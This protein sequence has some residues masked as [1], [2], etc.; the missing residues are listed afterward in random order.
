[1]AILN[2][3]LGVGS[4]SEC[5]TND[6]INKAFPEWESQSIFNKVGINSRFIC[7]KDEDSLTLALDA[8]QD[9]KNKYT[10][11]DFDFLIY[12]SNSS[13]NQAPGDG[14][15]FLKELG[16]KGNIGCID[17]NLGCSGFTY[18]LGLA[19]SLIDSGNCSKV[20]I[21]TTDAYSKF[22]SADDKSNMTLFGDG[23]TSSIVSKFPLN[24]KGWLLNN[25]KFGSFADACLD[26][27]IVNDKTR[28]NKKLIMDGK[29]IF[30]FSAN[31]V[32]KFISGQNVDFSEFTAIFHQANTFM[33][34]Y[35][36]RKLKISD[37]NFII[38][39]SE[40]GNTVSASIPYVINDNYERLISRKLFL[41]GFGIG[42]SYSSIK[43][44]KIN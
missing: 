20:L 15:L 10:N 17:L 11:L 8:Y 21:I 24:G 18:G 22:I 12:V 26:L 38:G 6:D 7:S 40:R 43:L 1:M 14:H 13:R 25:F 28:L 42:A 35:M 16:L 31:E 36:K 32:I 9:L 39:M 41:C 29:K 44:L 4:P 33:L 19:A 30:D 2:F 5:K 37:D 23:A 3:P 27:K 34:D